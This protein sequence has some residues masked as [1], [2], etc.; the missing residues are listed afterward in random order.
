MNEARQRHSTSFNIELSFVMSSF[1]YPDIRP[2]TT[3]LAESSGLEK[4][5]VVDSFQYSGNNT[6]QPCHRWH[7]TATEQSL[8]TMILPGLSPLLLN[9]HVHLRLL[10]LKVRSLRVNRNPNNNGVYAAV[11]PPS[12]NLNLYHRQ[13]VCVVPILH[14]N[15][16]TRRMVS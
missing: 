1:A 15:P 4:V 11:H 14:L 9:K 5:Q 7:P 10:R 12:S 8:T 13:L 2:T 6:P 16:T 3:A